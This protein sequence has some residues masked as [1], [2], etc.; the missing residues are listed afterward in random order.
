[1][2]SR[3]VF[4][5]DKNFQTFA[6]RSNDATRFSTISREKKRRESPFDK[7]KMSQGEPFL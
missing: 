3:Q 6:K 4:V 7:I 1:M 2:S 5:F